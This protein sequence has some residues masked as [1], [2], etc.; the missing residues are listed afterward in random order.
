MQPIFNFALAPLSVGASQTNVP[1]VPNKP[2]A[3]G[4]ARHRYEAILG[5]VTGAP[6]VGLQHA[7]IPG[8]WASTKTQAA[9]AN[10]GVVCTFTAGSQ[11]IAATAHGLSVGQWVGFGSSGQL[12]G[13]FTPN[14]LYEVVAVPSANAFEVKPYG[15][16][17]MAGFTIADTGS[18]THRVYAAQAVGVQFNPETSG[19]LTYLPLKAK[20]RLV[21]STAVG[22]VA[23]VLA[24]VVG[25][26]L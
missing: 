3:A 11:T 15:S 21:I 6:T 9:T 16:T 7:S 12:P 4:G 24:V 25:H 26:S 1:V 10:A 17:T 18:G 5:L 20:Q 13:A 23:Q 22:E 8:V 19:D 2:M 14:A